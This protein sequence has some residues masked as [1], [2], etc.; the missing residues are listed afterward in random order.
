MLEWLAMGPEAKAPV[1]FDHEKLDV[2]RVALDLVQQVEQL[3]GDLRLA[4]AAK[5]HL[6]RASESTVRNIVRAN[7]KRS[8][9]DRVPIF[10]VARGSALECAACLDVLQ[11]WQ[12]LAPCDVQDGKALCDRIV[13]MLMGLRNLKQP[14]VRESRSRY[15][16][17]S[18]NE[19]VALFAHESLRVYQSAL[20]FVTWCAALIQTE[21]VGLTRG[22]ELD[23]QATGIVLNVAEGNGKFSVA[24]RKR[25]HDIALGSGLQAAASLELLMARKCI[26]AEVACQGKQHL[27]EIVSMIGAL[28]RSLS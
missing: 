15:T 2:Y 13:A 19:S 10:D 16:V 1:V 3:L 4:V 9:A 18:E 12:L 14:Q 22:R 24:D 5:D 21:T 25:F 26:S 27:G 23:R 28:S 11:A 17:G 8:A 20:R 6:G 7:S